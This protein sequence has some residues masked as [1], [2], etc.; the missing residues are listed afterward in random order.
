MLEDVLG[1][2]HGSN[3]KAFFGERISC[4]NNAMS[5]L[6]VAKRDFPEIAKVTDHGLNPQGP[7]GR[8]HLYTPHSHAT[9]S[10]ASHPPA[11]NAFLRRLYTHHHLAPYLVAVTPP[12]T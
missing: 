6:I 12:Y 10:H 11:A 8:V 2:S 4:T 5:I 3:N 9:P 7:K 1:W